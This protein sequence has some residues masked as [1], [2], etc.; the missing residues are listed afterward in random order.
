MAF[1]NIHIFFFVVVSVMT[2][3]IMI[4][5]FFQDQQSRS[6]SGFRPCWRISSGDFNTVTFFKELSYN[7]WK[8]SRWKSLTVVYISEVLSYFVTNVSC[9]WNLC[10]VGC[11][12]RNL[13]VHLWRYISSTRKNSFHLYFKSSVIRIIYYFQINYIFGKLVEISIILYS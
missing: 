6:W 7:R 11:V 1:S 12:H 9:L 5:S 3:R 13:H 10:M 4:L 8:S 2:C